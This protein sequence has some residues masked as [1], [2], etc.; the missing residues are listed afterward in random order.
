MS[1]G[2]ID[3]DW[4]K[5]I[6]LFFK[7]PSGWTL[8]HYCALSPKAEENARILIDNGCPIDEEDECGNTPLIEAVL[9][10]KIKFAELL[11]KNGADI[12][13]KNFSGE[14]ALSSAAAWGH[15]KMVDFLIR[16]GA[17]LDTVDI[18]GRTPRDY[19]E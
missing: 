4:K 3:H 18:S 9:K 5:S 16:C 17:S 7:D 11:V 15:Q 1:G 8:M 19:I 13:H 2:V 10:N 14:T 12:N 6:N